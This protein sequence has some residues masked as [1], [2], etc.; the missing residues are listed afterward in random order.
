MVGEKVNAAVVGGLGVPVFLA[1]T[2][3]ADA[4]KHNSF[5]A[6]DRVVGE[7]AGGGEEGGGVLLERVDHGGKV[8]E[9]VGIGVLPCLGALALAKLV[10]RREELL[11]C[12]N[13]FDDR[14]QVPLLGVILGVGIILFDQRLL[15][16]QSL[17]QFNA[18]LQGVVIM[19]LLIQQLQRGFSDHGVWLGLET[20]FFP[21]GFIAA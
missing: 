2:L 5:V 20:N 9:A 18:D 13:V 17:Y 3:L 14:I 7:P 10:E 21:T 19:G 15:L 8:L 4:L 16:A 6:R 11:M 12:A 1:R